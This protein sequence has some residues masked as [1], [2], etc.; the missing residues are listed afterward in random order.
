[1][2]Q[3][4]TTNFT[5]SV[6]PA[7]PVMRSIDNI[8]SVTDNIREV[9]AMING[10]RVKE[11]GPWPMEDTTKDNSRAAPDSVFIHLETVVD[12]LLHQSTLLIEEV[13]D[14]CKLSL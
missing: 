12:E 9:R 8:S 1:M 5:A 10:R 6:V 14:F 7:G 4:P 13:Q 3:S 11:Y 2:N